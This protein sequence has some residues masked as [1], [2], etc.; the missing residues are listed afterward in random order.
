MT[1]RGTSFVMAEHGEQKTCILLTQRIGEGFLTDLSQLKKLLSLVED[2]AFIRDVAKV[3][4]VGFLGPQS[5]SLGLSTRETGV[6]TSLSFPDKD[7]FIFGVMQQV[8]KC[9]PA[10]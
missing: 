5:A 8:G 2:E 6:R 7:P 9:S 3:K 1:D 4:Q 10:K